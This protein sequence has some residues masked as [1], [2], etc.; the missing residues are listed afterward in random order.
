MDRARQHQVACTVFN[1]RSG[2]G[3][4]SRVGDRPGT[5]E[6][7]SAS[8]QHDIVVVGLWRGA[9]REAVVNESASC[10]TTRR[11]PRSR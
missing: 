3:Q 10:Q 11:F 1:N 8:V 6:T 7:G 2:S 4:R 5:G 9:V